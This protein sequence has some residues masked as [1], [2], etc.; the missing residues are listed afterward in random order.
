M[1]AEAASDFAKRVGHASTRVDGEQK[2]EEDI[3]WLASGVYFVTAVS[4]EGRVT[5]KFVKE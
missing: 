3:S 5:R 4:E 2:K 1:K